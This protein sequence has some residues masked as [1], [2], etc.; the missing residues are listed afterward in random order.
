MFT[1]QSAPQHVLEGC[2]RVPDKTLAER[3][4][5]APKRSM[6]PQ[7]EAG[8]SKG[9]IL[10]D[11]EARDIRLWFGWGTVLGYATGPR[12][13]LR[14]ALKPANRALFL[15]MPRLKRKAILRFIVNEHARRNGGDASCV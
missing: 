6:K 13:Y 1:R 5:S 11:V 3:R 12:D 8:G 9:E 2:G 14:D 10:T 15:A 7:R 4:W